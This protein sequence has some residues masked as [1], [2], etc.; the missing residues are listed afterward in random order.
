V[1]AEHMGMVFAAEGL[2]GSEKLLLLGYTNWTDP[3]GYCWPS[4]QRLADD[5]G[6]SRATV[7]RSKRKLVKRGLVKTVRRVNPRTGN[8]I[9]NLTRIN[10]PL[11][12]SLARKSTAYDDNLL[13]Q[14]VFDDDTQG[15]PE[16]TLTG[17]PDAPEPPS[18]LL[19]HQNDSDPESNRLRPGV[20]MTPTLSQIEAQSLRDPVGISLSDPGAR[21]AAAGDEAGVVTGERESRAVREDDAVSPQSAEK[22]VDGVT[23]EAVAEALASQWRTRHGTAPGRRQLAQ[24]AADAA[25]ALVDGD[26]PEWLV[27]SVVPFMAARRYLDLSRARTHRECPA[28]R[29]A[30]E[31]QGAAAGPDRDCPDCCGSGWT[32]DPAGE[33]EIVRCACTPVAA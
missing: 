24:V 4:E 33:A 6:V 17:T 27:S 30:Q 13:D 11:L 10:L 5:C 21:E 7:Q 25:D 20:K 3:Y 1:S 16:D 12:A 22:D 31:K 18:D 8:P 32:E 2:D 14:I 29:Q 28:P 15:S 19:T 23:G 9:S 26:D